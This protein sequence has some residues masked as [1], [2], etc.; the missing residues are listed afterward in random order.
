MQDLVPRGYEA[1]KTTAQ[2][3]RGIQDLGPRGQEANKT[4]VLGESR[5]A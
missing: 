5:Q 1:H 4:S 2:G 3:I